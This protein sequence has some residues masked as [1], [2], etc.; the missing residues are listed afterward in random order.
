MTPRSRLTTSCRA[1]A[2]ASTSV[3]RSFDAATPPPL[4]A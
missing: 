2:T 1:S 3:T 4:R